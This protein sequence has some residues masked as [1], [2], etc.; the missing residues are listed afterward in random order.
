MQ[1]KARCVSEVPILCEGAAHVWWMPSDGFLGYD[2]PIASLNDAE[3]DRAGRFRV[4]EARHQFI[5]ARILLRACLAAYGGLPPAYWRFVTNYYGR[6]ELEEQPLGMPLYFNVSHTNGAVGCVISNS[7]EIGMDI[8]CWRRDTDYERL[9]STVL[10]PF[11][12]EQLLAVGGGENSARCFYTFWTL[13]EAY[14]KARG[15][16]L[17]IPLQSFWFQIH[18]SAPMIDF[19]LDFDDHSDRWQFWRSELTPSHLVA[20][21][22]SNTRLNVTIFR[23]H[24]TDDGRLISDRN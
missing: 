7:A 14:I 3:R 10:V 22:S 20:V 12:R 4:E 15:L 11:E 2:P 5:A 16:G 13:K 1:S 24:L 19:S 6:P 17:S 18:G 9:V 23:A 8:E 21:A